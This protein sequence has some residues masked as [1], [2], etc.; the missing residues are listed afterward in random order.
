MSITGI[1]LCGG[2]STRMGA[3]KASLP[4]GD[5]T[6]LE[7]TVRLVSQS[8]DHVIV[9][10]RPEQVLP[11]LAASIIRDALDDRG[12]LAAIAQGLTASTTELNFI[13]ACDMPLLRPAVIARLVSLIGDFEACVPVS[14]THVMA[15]CGVYRKSLAT[16]ADAMVAAGQ[17]RVRDLL[18]QA[19]TQRVDAAAFRDI[20]PNLDSFVSC[21][22]PEEYQAALK[23]R[24]A[25]T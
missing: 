7:R 14:D 12:P 20:D 19:Q 4:F 15:L 10:A 8:T 23:C 16:V 6:L 2:R 5:E 24:P 22:T 9:V 11:E 3:D 13:T 17:L 25:G 21:N 18:A 1:V